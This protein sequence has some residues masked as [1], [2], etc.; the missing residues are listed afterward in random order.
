MLKFTG[1][2]KEVGRILQSISKYSFVGF[3]RYLRLKIMGKELLITGACQSCGKC[4]RKINLEGVGGWFRSKEDFLE[5]IKDYPDYKRFEITGKDEQGFLL[6]SC[7]WLTDTGHCRDHDNRLELCK[8][9]PDKN[10][11]YCGGTLP[12]GCGYSIREVRPFKKYLS[13]EVEEKEN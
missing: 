8:S 4:C 12:S 9:F 1:R 6:F 13:D 10:L 2:E 7:N 11:Y 3:L 5:A